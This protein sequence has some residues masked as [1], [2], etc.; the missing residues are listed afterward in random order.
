MTATPSNRLEAIRIAVPGDAVPD[1]ATLLDRAASD[2][3]FVWEQPAAQTS[4]VG[5]GIARHFSVSGC[6]R[7]AEAEAAARELFAELAVHGDAAPPDG[8]PLLVGGFAFG[9]ERAPGTAWRGFPPGR[10]VL[11]RILVARR[12]DRAWVTFAGPSGGRA[13]RERELRNLLG[14]PVPTTAAAPGAAPKPAPRFFAS[15][16]GPHAHFHA[17]VENAL[18]AIRRG[19]FEKVVVARSVRLHHSDAFRE[20]DVVDRLRRTYPSSTTFAVVRCGGG[21]FVGATPERLVRLHAGLVEAAAVAGS[22]PRGRNPEE[23]ARLARALRESKKE[24]AEHAI[25]VRGVR[26]ALA[27][28]CTALRSPESPRLQKLE[29]IQHLETP[30]RGVLRGEHS[31]LRLVERLHPTPAVGG[32]PSA[33]ALAWI[34]RH[35]GLERGW[36]AGPVGWIDA[37]GDGEFAVALRCA[38]LRNREAR[39]FA[40]AGI[41]DGSEPEAELNET[42]LKFRAF[43][44]PLL[45]I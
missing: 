8:G 23:D 31:V 5:I 43:L 15:A 13:A 45:E 32:A 6:D 39:L 33:A 7:F 16:D 25:V 18:A 36:Y 21:A 9:Q 28:V 20:A 38:L 44:G 10:L 24:Q 35:E 1:T 12:G 30:V 4:V 37:T 19:E 11:P 14:G 2:E 29:S 41:V 22:A 26:E 17:L 27:G 40:G 34:A 42:R 3:V